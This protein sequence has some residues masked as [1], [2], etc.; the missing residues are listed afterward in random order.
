MSRPIVADMPVHVRVDE[1]LRGHDKELQRAC[2]AR[3]RDPQSLRIVPF[4][5]LPDPGKVE[6]YASI[7]VT[8]IVLRVPGGG[9]DRV[10]PVLDEYAQ[11]VHG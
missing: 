1:V 4:G 10:L 5:T 7:G 8:E 2:E 11:L 6:Y 3:G 9:R